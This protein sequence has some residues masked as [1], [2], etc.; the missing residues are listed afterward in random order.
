MR[1]NYQMGILELVTTLL[2]LLALIFL[3][4]I[5]GIIL[6]AMAYGAPY[7][8]LAQNRIDTMK[9]LLKLKKGQ[10]MVDLGSGDGRIVMAFARAGIES[11]GYEINPVLVM[12]SRIRIR[13]AG[14]EKKAF[15][16]F[17]D[18]WVTNLADF[19]AVTLYGI[20]HIMKRLESKLKKELKPGSKVVTN[21]FKFPSLKPIQTRNKV[22]LY[23][24]D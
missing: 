9:D 10:K 18:F 3:L 20:A 5:F 17:K 14:L 12:I 13:R 16:H 22:L 19:D 4:G 6:Y 7:A 11:H 23:L 1:Y 8:A 21:Y 24:I 2:Y 15:I